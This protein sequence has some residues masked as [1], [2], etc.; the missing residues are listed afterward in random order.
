ML[1]SIIVAFTANT[2]LYSPTAR[3]SKA[4]CDKMTTTARGQLQF[5]VIT[6]FV[7]KQTKWHVLSLTPRLE[8]VAV[9]TRDRRCAR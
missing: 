3:F 7:A 6:N 2:F 8:I 1:T 9:G 4:G 5:A